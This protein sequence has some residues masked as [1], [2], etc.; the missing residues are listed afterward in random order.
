MDRPGEKLKRAREKLQLTYRQ[1]EK[2]SQVIAQRRGSDEFSIAISRLADI[3]NK[4]TIPTIYRIYTLCAIYRLDL[5]EVLRWYGVPREFLI[6]DAFG[7]SLGETH[8]VQLGASSDGI[9]P[10]IPQQKEAEI[11]L[12][13]TTFLSHF[14]RRWGK[15]PLQFLKGFDLR[16]HRYG[17]IGLDDWSMHPILHP[18]SLVLIDDRRRK[19]ATSGWSSEFDR[20]IYFLETRQGYLC[21]W[22]AM[23]DDRLVVQPHP[24][25]ARHPQS[26]AFPQQVDVLGQITGV[27]MLLE[28]KKRRL[29]TGATPA[30]SPDL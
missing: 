30:G 26:F 8:A 24:S 13:K 15:I 29:R 11:D 18:G 5:D 14:I 7:I 2:A 1:V 27:A 25:S 17:F 21:G 19:I 6:V 16:Q 23:D 3:E 10:L 12:E 22:C 9:I 4:G 28:P 20:P